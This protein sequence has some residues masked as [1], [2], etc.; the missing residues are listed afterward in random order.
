LSKLYR[1]KENTELAEIY[2][3]KAEEIEKKFVLPKEIAAEFIESFG[4]LLKEVKED[5]EDEDD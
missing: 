1:K 4:D 3:Q 2:E 5:D